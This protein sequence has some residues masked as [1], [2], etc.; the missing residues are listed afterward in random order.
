MSSPGNAYELAVIASVA[1]AFRQVIRDAVVYLVEDVIANFGSAFPKHVPT[2][3]RK[4]LQLRSSRS[5]REPLAFV[6]FRD[7]INV[8]PDW[9]EPQLV[10]RVHVA[11]VVFYHFVS[12]FVA[13]SHSARSAVL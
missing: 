2:E 8:L 10:Q 1:V 4:R 3:V 12:F 11:E 6:L 5:A 13:G 7:R 9:S